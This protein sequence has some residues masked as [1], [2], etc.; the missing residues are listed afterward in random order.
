MLA[1]LATIEIKANRIISTV[2]ISLSF[3]FVEEIGESNNEITYLAP[4]YWLLLDPWLPQ[5]AIRLNSPVYDGI[6]QNLQTVFTP[7]RSNVCH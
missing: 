4:C 7:D 5:V 1:F 3:L 2:D 6:F